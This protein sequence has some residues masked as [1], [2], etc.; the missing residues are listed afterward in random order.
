MS[1]T[2]IVRPEGCICVEFRDTGGFRIA[3]LTCPVHGV[4]GTDPGDGYW[5]TEPVIGGDE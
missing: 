1:A 4:S 5:D 3:D 2:Q